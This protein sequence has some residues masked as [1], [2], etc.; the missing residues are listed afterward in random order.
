MLYCCVCIVLFVLNGA[1]AVDLE[2]LLSSAHACG[3]WL[4]QVRR[5][6]H[7]IPELSFQQ[8]QQQQRTA[9][10]LRRVCR[11]SSTCLT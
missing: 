9:A 4:K 5:E 2:A 10:R 1:H 3:P 6:L 7:Q 8:L 11:R